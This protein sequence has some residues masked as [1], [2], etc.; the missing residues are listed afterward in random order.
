MMNSCDLVAHGVFYSEFLLLTHDAE[1]G[2]FCCD[3]GF[4]T[5]LKCHFNGV[6][7]PLLQC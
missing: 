1:V 5:R 4:V 2:V 6:K 3:G 7:V